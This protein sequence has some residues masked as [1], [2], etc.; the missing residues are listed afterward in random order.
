MKTTVVKDGNDFVI[1]GTKYWI[2]NAENAG[3]FIVFANFNP[4]A[5]YK[6]I[7]CFLVDRN[8]PGVSVSKKEDKLGLRASSTCPVIFENVRVPASNLIGK[9]GKGYKYA[10]EILNEG[11][12]GIAAQMIGLAQGCFDHA[13]KYTFERKQFNN[14]LFDFQVRS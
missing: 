12:I 5:G 6:G 7:S 11:R 4:S 3:F 10:I 2:T 1:N 8:E 9:L 14:R 13:I